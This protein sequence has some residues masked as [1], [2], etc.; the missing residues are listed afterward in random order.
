[1]DGT[2]PYHQMCTNLLVHRRMS[3]CLNPFRCPCFREA[4]SRLSKRPWRVDTLDALEAKWFSREGEAKEGG[5]GAGVGEKNIPANRPM[6]VI[7]LVSAQYQKCA[8]QQVMDIVVHIVLAPPCANRIRP[9][10]LQR[11]GLCNWS[12]PPNKFLRIHSIVRRAGT[13]ASAWRR[14]IVFVDNAGADAVLGMLPFARELLRMG[15]EV[16]KS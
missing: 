1:M 5:A 15:A 14:A 8:W 13:L 12:R 11:S 4:R 6:L 10:R 3:T 16:C 7:F 2:C 9:H